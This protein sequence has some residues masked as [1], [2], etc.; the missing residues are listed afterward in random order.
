MRTECLHGAVVAYEAGELSPREQTD[1][2][3]H[4]STCAACRAAL[5]STREVIGRLR[6]VPEVETTRDLAPL[7]FARLGEGPRGV[8]RPSRWPRIA[9]I[10]AL[11]TLLAGGFTVWS[12]KRSATSAKPA[13]TLADDNAASVARALDWFCQN[14]EPD[15]SWNAEKWG[16]NRRF[17]IALT[18][19]PTL[20]LLGA[21]SF[22]PERSSAIADAILWLQKQQT[23]SGAFGPDFQGS[24]YNQGIATF[25]L[26][27]AYEREPNTRLKQSLD[28]ALNT[29]IARQTADGGWGYLYSPVADRSIT[30]WHIEALELANTLGWESARST[31]RR[32]RDWLAAHPA[33]RSDSEEPSD[34]PSAL[35]AATDGAPAT[36]RAAIDFYHAYFVTATLKRERDQTSRQRLAAI[37]RTLLL[38]QVVAGSDFGSWTPDDRWGRVGGRLYSTALAS[39][40]LRDR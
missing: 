23:E 1:F 32:G 25:A 34:S 13:L 11:L 4:L 20:A 7:I 30:D 38:Q 17:E 33:P 9:A 31:L 26:L 29:I 27:R 5:E 24:P 19:L 22:T 3:L 28:A 39:L 16:G 21:E 40:S 2:E 14:Q 35:L 37:R 36:E 8:G 18:A 6:S 12:F 15:G 10:A